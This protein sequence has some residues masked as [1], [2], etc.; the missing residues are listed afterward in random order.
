MSAGYGETVVLE[1]IRLA[2]P[3]GETLAIIGRNDVSKTT[4]LATVMGHNT[5]HG[6]DVRLHGRMFARLPPHRCSWIEQNMRLA[7]DISPRTAVM[8]R[9]RIVFDG[10]SE[11]L[12]RDTDRLHQLIGVAKR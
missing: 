11:Q 10:P 1:D 2:L 3:A 12:R 6:G 7:L 5:L 4:L 9:G 8:D